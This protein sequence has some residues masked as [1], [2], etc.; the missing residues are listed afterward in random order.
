MNVLKVLRDFFKSA[1]DI[2]EVLDSL[3]FLFEF[4]E[5][6]LT[7]DWLELAEE[8][9]RLLLSRKV[10]LFGVGE[11]VIFPEALS[12]VPKLIFRDYK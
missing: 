4:L 11:S 12:L 8:R 2:E 7:K 6:V 5:L 10:R 3:I 9:G 1:D